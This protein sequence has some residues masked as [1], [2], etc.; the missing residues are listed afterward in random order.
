MY[1]IYIYIY[2]ICIYIYYIHVCIYIGNG[3]GAGRRGWGHA[4]HRRGGMSMSSRS[5]LLIS[6]SLLPLHYVSIDTCAYRIG[7]PLP[8]GAQVGLFCSLA[9]LFCLYSRSLLTPARTGSG[10][11][12][13]GA[14]KRISPSPRTCIRG[15]CCHDGNKKTK[16]IKSK[17]K[18]LARASAGGADMMVNIAMNIKK[19]HLNAIFLFFFPS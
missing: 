8:W 2:Y 15:R 4:R 13:H 10:A 16:K 14:P 9:G 18:I 11:H 19:I 6:R 5:L 17:K 7:S 1:T 3:H 12:C